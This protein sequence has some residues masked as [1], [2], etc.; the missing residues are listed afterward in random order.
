MYSTY[1]TYSKVAALTLGLL[2]ASRAHM[3]RLQQQAQMS[4]TQLEV[5]VRKN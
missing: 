3:Q 2:S 1:S 5:Q 4:H